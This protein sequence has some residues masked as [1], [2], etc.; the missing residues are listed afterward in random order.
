MRGTPEDSL[1]YCTK[2]D[3]Q[4]FVFGTLPQQGKRNDLI[5]V[6][7]RILSGET[8]RNIAMDIEGAPTVVKY[9]RGL[10]ALRN[11]LRP[12][13]TAV[14][15]IFWCYGKT[16]SGKTKACFEEAER[17]CGTEGCWISAMGLQWFDGYDGQPAVVID[18]FRSKHIKFAYLLRLLDRYP[19][20]VAFK[21]GFVDWEP[22]WIFI[23]TSNSISETFKVRGQHI[24]EDLLQLERRITEGEFE[25]PAAKDRFFKRIRQCEKL[26]EQ[27][28]KD[29]GDDINLG[30]DASSHSWDEGLSGEELRLREQSDVRSGIRDILGEPDDLGFGFGSGYHADSRS[31]NDLSSE[32]WQPQSGE[33]GEEERITRDSAGRNL[34]SM[35]T[36]EEEPLPRL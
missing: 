11:L 10:T 7:E 32:L 13:R 4:A 34:E 26:D 2:E 36:E 5:S 24:P 23:T 8:L 25:F 27:V 16:G 18:D 35:D 1:V 20:R 14:P 3:L 28:G 9:F 15:R 21:G 29:G 22:V 19:L 33:E 17:L 12:R 6:T 31:G 30:R